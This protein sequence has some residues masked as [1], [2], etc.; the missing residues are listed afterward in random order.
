MVHGLLSLQN[1][2]CWCPKT[3]DPFIRSSCWLSQLFG[4]ALKGMQG[5]EPTGQWACPLALWLPHSLP[6]LTPL[7]VVKEG[8]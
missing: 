4:P 1:E 3:L 8:H 2:M 7:L 6:N 5:G